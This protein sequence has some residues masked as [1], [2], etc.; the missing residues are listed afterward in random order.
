[1]V[2]RQEELLRILGQLATELPNPLWVALVD[3]DGLVVACVPNEPPVAPESFSAM[4]A[5]SVM[6]GERVLNEIA[7][8]DLRYTSA[9]GS[10]RQLLTVMLSKE[11][12]L[13]IGLG[14]E[15]PPH[16]TFGPL[17]RRVPELLQALQR[18]FTPE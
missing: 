18:R 12:L 10:K 7:G 5:A 2:T 3:H 9:A 16:D 11:R 4:T 8:G 6:L 17:S 14:P 1:M 15:V 13:S